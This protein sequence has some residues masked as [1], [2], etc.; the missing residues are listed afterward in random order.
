MSRRLIAYLAATGAAALTLGLSSTAAF[1]G[2]TPAPNPVVTTYGPGPCP[3]QTGYAGQDVQPNGEPTCK[4]VPVQHKCPP[5]EVRNADGRCVVPTPVVTRQR[6]QED[7]DLE[8]ST[9]L[10]NGYVLADGPIVFNVG[11]DASVGSSGTLDKFSQGG[12]SVLVRHEVLP[13]ATFDAQTCSLTGTQLNQPFTMFDGTGADAGKTATGLY[14]LDEIFSFGTVNGRCDAPFWNGETVNPNTLSVQPKFF[15]IAVQGVAYETVVK[16]V[17]YVI[18]P[19]QGHAPQPIT[20]T[21]YN[22]LAG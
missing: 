7:V 4:P 1:A 5:G 12:N 19:C 21:D 15:D 9:G 18:P 13:D 6:L 16:T 14:T 8:I 11:R 22:S 20:V 17:K 3:T 10:P 2:Q